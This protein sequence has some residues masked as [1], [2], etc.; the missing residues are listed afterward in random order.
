MSAAITI[1][2]KAL[3]ACL[4]FAEEHGVPKE[5]LLGPLGA[6]SALLEDADAHVPFAWVHHVWTEAPR[7]TG[8]PAFGLH[9]AESIVGRR[10]HVIDYVCAHGRCPRNIF[11]SIQRYQRLLMS[12]TRFHLDVADGVATF[13]HP[14]EPVVGRA[15]PAAV[16][17]FVVAQWL[18][19]VRGRSERGF[20][21][22]RVTFQHEAPDDTSEHARIFQAPVEFGQACDSIV[23][24]ADL[25]D[26]ELQGADPTLM[27][28]L[29][30]HA[31]A[32]LAR[33]PEPTSTADALRRHLIELSPA[34]EA[35]I[36][37]AARALA[38]SERSLQRRLSDEN[39]SFKAVL[40]DVRRDLALAYLRDPRLSIADVG[41]LVGF[42]EA[43]AF[44]RAFR[45]WTRTSPAEWR[46][47]HAHLAPTD[48][49]LAAA[50]KTP[51]RPGR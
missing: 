44:S 39:T 50:V 19:R 6:D 1:T 23:F 20:P 43:S 40:D 8:D 7:L 16:D 48:T 25:L 28:I 11:E 12:H 46:R 27:V 37:R 35:D 29:H 10:A 36:E 5:A 21:L 14:R 2:A 26:L 24:D 15:R 3:W 33:M 30:R 31:D 42:G 9:V 18:L 32:L 4:H 38:M 41:F 13:S 22:R 45:R 34:A 49:S 17:D 51:D 47:R